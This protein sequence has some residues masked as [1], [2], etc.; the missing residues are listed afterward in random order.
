MVMVAWMVCVTVVVGLVNV[1]IVWV[2]WIVRF[3]HPTRPADCKVIERSDVPLAIT[4]LLQV[5]GAPAHCLFIVLEHRR[6]FK[7]IM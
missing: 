2:V 6:H 3:K 1:S 7:G 4:A 5:G